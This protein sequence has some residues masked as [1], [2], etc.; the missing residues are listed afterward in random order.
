MTTNEIIPVILCG[1]S[2][3]R[4]WPM[5]RKETPK[6]FLKLTDNDTLLQKTLKR[7]MDILGADGSRIVTITLMGLRDATHRQLE[8]VSP[9]LTEHILLEPQARNTAAAVALA[10]Q[11]V[12]KEFGDDALL[13]V[14]PADH[15]IGDEAALEVALMQAHTMA[16]ENYMVTFGIQPT[17]AETGYGYIRKGKVLNGSSGYGVEAFVEK[18]TREIA[19]EFVLSG[20]YLW[21]SGMHLFKARTGC[22]NFLRLAPNTWADVKGS[23]LG[24]DGQRQPTLIHYSAVKNEPFEI[25]VMEKADKVA[26]VPCDPKWS[27]IGCWESLWEIKN[28]DESG[29]A[30]EGHAVCQDTKNSMII[31]QDRLVTCVGLEN[32]III[33]TGDSVLVAH[34]DS[35]ASLKI[36]VQTLQGL[37]KQETI[38]S[39]TIHYNWGRMRLV[40]ETTGLNIRELVIKAGHVLKVDH[41][42]LGHS[43]WLITGGKARFVVDGIRKEV[44]KNQTIWTTHDM[45]C[46]IA[47]M[48]GQELKLS[49]LHYTR[50]ANGKAKIKKDTVI[51]MPVRERRILN[52]NKNLAA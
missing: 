43:H 32:V 36:L 20:D 33:E 45:V 21:S 16:K 1:G 3:T 26:V 40:A 18:P 13:W 52:Q 28:K 38:S 5:S 2:G 23:S 44:G 24:S 29:N 7:T 37:K 14:L 51:P 9:L 31:A 6:Q 8:E 12:Q 25:A 46:S 10:I 39:A 22:D 35:S 42:G 11:Y 4:L 17:R 19:E 50:S 49:E 48:D 30:L 41:V 27:D 47:G 34:K 15:F